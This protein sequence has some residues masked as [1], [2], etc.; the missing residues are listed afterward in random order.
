[1]VKRI[2]TPLLVTIMILAGAWLSLRQLGW[3]GSGPEHLP[4]VSPQAVSFHAALGRAG[5]RTTT[6]RVKNMKS[7]TIDRL[8]FAIEGESSRSFFVFTTRDDATAQR[9][10][11]EYR[12]RAPSMRVESRGVLL[13]Q[14][15]DELDEKDAQHVRDAFFAPF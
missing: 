15:P 2:L 13:L 3:A 14:L 5:V 6:A 8:Y 9:L 4:H 10:R 1:M 12:A 7:D 11:D